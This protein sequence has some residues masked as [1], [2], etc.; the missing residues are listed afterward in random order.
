MRTPHFTTTLPQE[1]IDALR[2]M[3]QKLGLSI[4]QLITKLVREE[5]KREARRK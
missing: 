3:A 5:L 4:G 1:T 2:V